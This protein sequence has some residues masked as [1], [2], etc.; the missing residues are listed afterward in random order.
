MMNYSD[1]DSDG[2]SSNEDADY[3]PSGDDLS[4][5][6]I[7]QCEKEDP[8]HEE[9]DVPHPDP[10]KKE[11]KKKKNLVSSVRKKK[12]KAAVQV[13]EEKSEDQAGESKPAHKDDEASQKKKADDLWALFLS[14][15][16]SRPKACSAGSPSCSTA[17]G[18]L[19]MACIYRDGLMMACIYR[20]GLMM[21]CIYR[22]GLMMA[23]IYRD[24]LMMPDDGVHL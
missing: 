4:E 11:A 8:L 22:D 10:G 7:N 17:Q 2:Y 12:K 9:D 21:A 15:V 5:E 18:C 24:G 23:C 6:D 19:M 1:Y 14:D 3:V 16:G 20:D 13:E